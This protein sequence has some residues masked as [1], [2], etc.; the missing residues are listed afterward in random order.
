LKQE[1]GLIYSVKDG[2]HGYGQDIPD[3]FAKRRRELI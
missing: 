3:E 2:N 1:D